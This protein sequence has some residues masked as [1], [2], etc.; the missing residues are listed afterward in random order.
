[1]I[2]Q[3]NEAGGGGGRERE[4]ERDRGKGGRE[5]KKETGREVGRLSTAHEDMGIPEGLSLSSIS[6]II[7][8][9]ENISPK[10]N[11]CIEDPL[12]EF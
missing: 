3:I 9:R 1:M 11:S 5:G 12:R 6:S 4:R 2:N 10:L 7:I 8:G